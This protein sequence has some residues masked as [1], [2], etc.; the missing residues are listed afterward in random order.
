MTTTQFTNLDRS[1]KQAFSAVSKDV[2]RLRKRDNL[3]RE[4][5]AKL[6]DHLSAYVSEDEFSKNIQRLD[7]AIRP[8]ASGEDLALKAGQLK[9]EIEQE[10]EIRQND[11]VQITDKIT[12]LL[13]KQKDT[14]KDINS[15][16]DSIRSEFKKTENLKHEVKEVREMKKALLNLDSMY[17]SKKKLETSFEEID[18][19]YDLLEQLDKRSVKEDELNK[20]KKDVLSKV[21]KFDARIRDAEDAE[22]A[23]ARKV[24][25]IYDVEKHVDAMDK[26][27][28]KTDS[29]VAELEQLPRRLAALER[30][31]ASIRG[32][33]KKL[34][35][36]S[37]IE[38]TNLDLMR[39]ISKLDT[40]LTGQQE[41]IKDI[42]TKLNDV[43]KL[44]NKMS[45]VSVRKQPSPRS[46]KQESS[47]VQRKTQRLEREG[48]GKQQPEQ[49]EE[50]KGLWTKI[51]DWFT[52]EIDEE[53]E[54][55]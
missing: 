10:R 46:E 55:K 17:A 44:F 25:D 15:R 22:D 34:D 38:K 48:S 39:E 27:L 19:I 26:T 40:R 52:E 28:M 18:E 33:M 41:S 11:I 42:N 1:L 37:Q 45:E 32:Q 51:L 3:L 47:R 29:R 12:S 13:K 49:A 24:K 5:I 36:S 6:S 21:S 4:E 31:A 9:A 53:E 50:K 16:I 43:I 2:N 30:D 23:L 54:R 8:L 14:E 20:F 35:N 7:E